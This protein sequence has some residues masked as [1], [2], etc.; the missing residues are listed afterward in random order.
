MNPVYGF[1]KQP[2]GLQ[3]GGL[4]TPADY[5]APGATW[6]KITDLT[7]VRA[8]DPVKRDYSTDADQ[9][10]VPHAIMTPMEQLVLLRLTSPKKSLPFDKAMG[11]GTLNLTKQPADPT[12]TARALVDEALAEEIAAGKIVIELVEAERQG[13]ALYRSVTWF[14]ATLRTRNTTNF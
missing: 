9:T 8:I 5:P 7:D 12:R 10:G 4:G 2:F 13:G 3:G 14:D 6:V 11:D 1:G